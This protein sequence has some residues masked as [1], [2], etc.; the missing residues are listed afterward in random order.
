MKHQ[1]EQ[2]SREFIKVIAS[3]FDWLDSG[4]SVEQFVI[5]FDIGAAGGEIPEGFSE[6]LRETLEYIKEMRE[7]G[8]DRNEVI[9][10][11]RESTV[12]NRRKGWQA[13]TLMRELYPYQ[14]TSAHGT[15]R[16]IGS[17]AEARLQPVGLYLTQSVVLKKFRCRALFIGESQ[18]RM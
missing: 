9:A 2:F 3:L 1:D 6:L 11:F 7:E 18:L 10:H 16:T 13:M 15:A 4:K 14:K 12:R 5:P 17:H 8:A